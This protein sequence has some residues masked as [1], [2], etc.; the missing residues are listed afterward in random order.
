MLA[1]VE[2]EEGL[3][4]SIVPPDLCRRCVKIRSTSLYPLDFKIRSSNPENFFATPSS[5]ELEP[6]S[7]CMLE[8]IVDT[9]TGYDARHEKPRL[10]FTFSTSE[11]FP[12]ASMDF[13]FAPFQRQ[14]QLLTQGDF[15]TRSSSS[16]PVADGKISA[17]SSVPRAV[18][19]HI[20]PVTSAIPHATSHSPAPPP[21]V[22]DLIKNGAAPNGGSVINS[23]PLKVKSEKIRVVVRIRPPVDAQGSASRWTYDST[24][25]SDE[26]V[27]YVFHRV[28]S[29]TESNVDAF[30]AAEIPQLVKHYLSGFNVALLM[31]GQTNS[32]KTHTMFGSPSEPAGVIHCVLRDI[33]RSFDPATDTIT[34]SMLEIYNEEVRDLLVRSSPPLKVVHVPSTDSFDAESLSALMVKDAGAAI[35][36]LNFGMQQGSTGPSH[37]NQR[38]SRAHTIFRLNL[39]RKTR[40]EG[41][42]IVTQASELCFVDLAGSESLSEESNKRETHHINLSLAHLKRAIVELSHRKSFVSFRSSALTK[43]LKNALQSN[44]R[45]VIMLT[46]CL[47]ESCDR[48]TRSTL[49]FGTLAKS[50]Q[51]TV[52]ANIQESLDQGG[53]D[54]LRRENELLRAQVAELQQLATSS[55][56][57]ASGQAPSSHLHPPAADG[58]AE[59]SIISPLRVYGPTVSDFSEYLEAEGK[60]SKLLAQTLLF[61]QSGCPVA[62]LV[63]PSTRHGMVAY[64]DQVLRLLPN[65]GGEIVAE[66]GVRLSLASVSKIVLGRRLLA[67][68][69]PHAWRRRLTLVMTS[70]HAPTTATTFSFQ[71]NADED[72][73]AWVVCLSQLAPH[74]QLLWDPATMRKYHLPVDSATAESISESELLF[75]QEHNVDPIGFVAAKSI[76]KSKEGL[77]SLLQLRTSTNLTLFDANAVCELFVQRG[78]LRKRT[79]LSSK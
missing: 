21:L 47:D 13:V 64:K 18:S 34:A 25:V 46:V 31:Y 57:P 72:F 67:T 50:I 3:F 29:S 39:R 9:L 73:E 58:Q 44:S 4:S 70:S 71:C 54:A 51:N 12:A 28:I 35:L 5:G 8:V 45:T 49:V 15:H 26:D 30:N 55:A 63:A 24:S 19:A 36:A 60:L 42:R 79:V 27:A 10:K 11:G 65:R 53:V 76:V 17:V 20:D 48:E 78:I 37:L 61:L 77:V 59:M 16:D 69:Q 2:F 6:G 22:A 52:R 7:S 23:N 75:C 40:A 41:N 68:E 14:Q 38:S 56:P 66:R 62:V 43:L 1:V 32:G 74:A 33:F